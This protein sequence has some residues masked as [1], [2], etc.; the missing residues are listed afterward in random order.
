VPDGGPGGAGDNYLQLTSNGSDGSG[1][2][3]VAINVSQWAGDYV[4]LGVT[5]ISASLRN[6]GATDLSLRLYFADPVLGPPTNE[7]ISTN[8]IPIAAQLGVDNIGA[9]PEPG[10]GLLLGL[11]LVALGARRR[12]NQGFVA[13]RGSVACDPKSGRYCA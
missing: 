9:I 1:G 5:G 2:R 7:A 10:T 8:A 13:A 11:G 6:L 4:A 12:R 3:L